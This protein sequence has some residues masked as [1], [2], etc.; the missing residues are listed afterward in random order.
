MSRLVGAFLLLVLTVS[1]GSAS[2]PGAADDHGPGPASAALVVSVSETPDAVLLHIHASGDVEPGSV[3][4]RFAGPKTVV[5]AH[6]AEG[7]PIRSQALR[8]P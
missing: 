8:L 5:L 6:D 2:D 4:V 1:R 7:R 3:E